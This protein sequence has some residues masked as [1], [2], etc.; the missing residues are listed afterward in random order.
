[1]SSNLNEI[2]QCTEKFRTALEQSDLSRWPTLANF[3]RGSCGDASLLLEKYLR[4]GGFDD[5]HYVYGEIC[6]AGQWHTHAWLQH[7]QLI[8]DITAD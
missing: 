2:R 1:M 7:D 4:D 5:F 8:V 3:P 6:E